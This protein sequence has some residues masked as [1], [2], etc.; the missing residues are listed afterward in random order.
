MQ[1]RQFTHVRFMS[2]QKLFMVKSKMWDKLFSNFL[3]TIIT[4]SIGYQNL[5]LMRKEKIITS[6]KNKITAKQHY[7]P[8]TKTDL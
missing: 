4:Y 8:T 7:R 6:I 2:L 1:Y 3:Q 5:W